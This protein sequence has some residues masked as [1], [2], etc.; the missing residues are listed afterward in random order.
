MAR[1]RQRYAT[2]PRMLFLWFDHPLI[3]AWLERQ[4][5]PSRLTTSKA[6]RLRRLRGLLEMLDRNYL[7]PSDRQV[8]ALRFLVRLTDAVPTRL[9]WRDLGRRDGCATG[10]SAAQA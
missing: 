6:T 1:H 3:E 8:P 2:V 9:S 7:G 5:A 4:I 10:C